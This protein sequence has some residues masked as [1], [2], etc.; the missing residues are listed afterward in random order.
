VSDDDGIEEYG[1]NPEENA[2]DFNY[3]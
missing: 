3:R 1:F 2:F